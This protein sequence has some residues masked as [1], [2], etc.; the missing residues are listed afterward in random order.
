MGINFKGL[1]KDIMQ[2]VTPPTLN[3][4]KLTDRQ[5]TLLDLIV[6][7]VGWKDALLQLGYSSGTTKSGI[8]KSSAFRAELASRV[9]GALAMNG[10]E[11]V[12]A[13]EHVMNS[14]E[15]PGAGIKLKA[16]G[17]FLDR[18]GLGKVERVRHEGETVNALFILPPKEIA[19]E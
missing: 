5:E 7:G 9:E 13:M 3:S 14:P 8:L 6:E 18:M 10:M 2:D 15:S 19:S 1:S 11:A 17:D 16:A 12:Y 4:S